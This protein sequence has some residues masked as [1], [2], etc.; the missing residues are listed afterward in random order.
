MRAGIFIGLGFRARRSVRYA[1][2]AP[3]KEEKI[4]HFISALIFDYFYT[5]L[6]LCVR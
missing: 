6:Q 1:H 5:R 4:L 3:L 2:C